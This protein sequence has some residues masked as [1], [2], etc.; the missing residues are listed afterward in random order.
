MPDT[1]I[2]V[3]IGAGMV[4]LGTLVAVW[5]MISIVRQNRKGDPLPE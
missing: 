2:A 4:V 3:L 1:P 5:V